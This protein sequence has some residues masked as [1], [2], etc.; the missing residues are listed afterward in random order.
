MTTMTAMVMRKMCRQLTPIRQK[1]YSVVPMVPA[2]LIRPGGGLRW[3]GC[4]SSCGCMWW[5]YIYM[6]VCA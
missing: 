4:H 6:C 3:G 2:G 1:R 5:M